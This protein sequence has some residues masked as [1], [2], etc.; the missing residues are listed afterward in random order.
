[1]ANV[2]A[3]LVLTLAQ[4]AGAQPPEVQPE[5]SFGDIVNDYRFGDAEAAVE[6][7]S[8]V[9]MQGLEGGG[10]ARSLL[11]TESG[12]RNGTFGRIAASAPL[13]PVPPG[14]GLTGMFELRSYL[15]YLKLTERLHA[16]RRSGDQAAILFVRAWYVA[17]VSY[18]QHER[19]RCADAL[20]GAA[21]RDFEDDPAIL[22]LSGSIA[23]VDGRHA[24]AADRLRRALQDDPGLS[25]ARLRLGSALAAA[26]QVTAGRREI[27]Q[28]I[29]DARANGDVFT[30]H[31][32]LRS[33]ETLDRR[34]GRLIDMRRHAA[35]A[36]A[37]E[38]FDAETR[39]AV[40][41][42]DPWTVYRAAQY[43]RLARILSTLRTFVRSTPDVE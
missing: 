15:A 18:C 9:T 8:R 20:L 37:I 11:L 13:V 23:E 38:P 39:I 21:E 5:R 43:H 27:E 1:M 6:E 16:S 36:A 29:V 24:D 34:E 33:L 17:A 30:Q 41:G 12:M 4:M 26:G 31:F 3:V 40:Q 25:E 22:L 2:L 14:V 42:R 35:E 19:L 7:A 28:S 32:A 10:L